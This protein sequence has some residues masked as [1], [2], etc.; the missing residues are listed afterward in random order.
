MIDELDKRVMRLEHS[1]KYL[2]DELANRSIFLR[3][4]DGSY[5]GNPRKAKGN[6]EEERKLCDAPPGV[7]HLQMNVRTP[8]L[9]IKVL[10][11]GLAG[12]YPVDMLTNLPV[13]A[14]DEM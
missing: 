4:G 11:V 2:L 7:F 6:T 13:Q 5:A 10:P 14:L 9:W 12:W 1:F 3:Q 8:L